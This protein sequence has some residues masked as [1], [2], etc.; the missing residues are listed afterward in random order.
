MAR[1]LAAGPQLLLLDEP[2][3]ALDPL[4]RRRI[5]TEIRSQLDDWDIPVITVTH[6]P[7]DIA[8]FGDEVI[9]YEDGRVLGVLD[10]ESLLESKD[11][12]T[13]LFNKL[14]RFQQ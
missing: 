13:E 2:F 6:D 8:M 14:N 5:R 12:T 11:I 4:L 9:L 7:D 3:S 10:A 1:A